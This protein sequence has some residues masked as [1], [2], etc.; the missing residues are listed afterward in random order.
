LFFAMSG[1]WATVKDP[2]LVVWLGEVPHQT[3]FQDLLEIGNQ[4]GQAKWAKILKP[5]T[6]AIG[7]SNA[8]EAARAAVVLN[9]TLI[10]NQKI[11]ASPWKSNSTG[12]GNWKANSWG[13]SWGNN[14][15]GNNWKGNFWKGSWGG[16]GWG[17]KGSKWGGYPVRQW[18]NKQNNNWN[19]VNNLEKCV[20]IGGV[21]DGTS[22]NELLELGKQVG[23]CKWAQVFAKGQAVLGFATE[24][25]VGPAIL[26]LDGV[27]LGG[28]T[29]QADR[30]NKETKSDKLS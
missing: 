11:Q 2:E 12:G 8:E 6:A 21:P 25:A 18:N 14:W 16:K 10:D 15:K 23:D 20:W 17:G 29:I 1:M 24:S 9:G 3:T 19:K 22:Y 5:G 7:F 30:W 26:K 28:A 27:S 4:A 13:N